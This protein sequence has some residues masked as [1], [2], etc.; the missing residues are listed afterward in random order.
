MRNVW[1][2]GAAL[3]LALSTTYGQIPAPNAVEL[4]QKPSLT[5]SGRGEVYAAPDRAT[6]RLGA[7]A[8]AP[9]AAA[10]QA[11][12]NAIMDKALAAIKAVGVAEKALRTVGL[13]VHPIYG[14]HQPG[15]EGEEPKI[16]GYRASN[17]VQVTLDELTKIGK[18]IDA[19]MNAGANQLEGVS[20]E[21]RNDTEARAQALRLAAAEASAKA[22]TLSEALGAPLGNI[23]E[24]TEGGVTVE[25]PRPMFD[26]AVRFREAS[27]STQVQAGEVR[28]EASVTLRYSLRPR[29]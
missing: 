7:H 26:M 11:S 2:L 1:I 3:L 6:V 27:A 9:D 28:V 18:V 8:N 16:V 14:N 20:F 17:T 12:V 5:V 24:I 23:A 15:R 22:R 13:N 25:P 21:L 19:A 29:Q 10:A 4:A